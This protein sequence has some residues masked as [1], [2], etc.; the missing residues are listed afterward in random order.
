MI[1]SIRSHI[2]ATIE[3]YRQELKAAMEKQPM[4]DNNNVECCGT[5]PPAKSQYEIKLAYGVI[6]RYSNW[7]RSP[8]KT[9][10]S[11]FDD[12]HRKNKE[13]TNKEY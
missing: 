11:I 3:G 12:I 7:R 9:M 13:K 5:P 8:D 4:K 10:V 1:F 6:E 2:Q